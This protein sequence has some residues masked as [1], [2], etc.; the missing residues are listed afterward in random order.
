[1]GGYKQDTILVNAHKIRM[2]TKNLDT[3]FKWSNHFF[4]KLNNRPTEDSLI[5]ASQGGNNYI[6]NEDNVLFPD[7]KGVAIRPPLNILRNYNYMIRSRIKTNYWETGISIYL[8][9]DKIKT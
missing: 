9:A 3:E 5:W 4:D 1:M 6:E 7:D 8:I 2:E